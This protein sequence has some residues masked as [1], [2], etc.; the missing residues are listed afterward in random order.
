MP[1]CRELAAEHPALDF[2]GV[3]IADAVARVLRF[4][5]VA[6]KTFLITIADRTVTGLIAR[7][8][9]V[10]PYQVPVA[11]YAMTCHSFKGHTGS[12]MAMG[13]RTPLALVDA[14]ASGRMAIAEAVANIAAAPIG[15]IHHIKLSG[16]WMCAC[17][18]DGEDAALYDTVQAVGMEFCPGLGIAIPV[19]KDSLSMRAIWEDT[20]GQ[21]H[22]IVA[23]LSLVV[24]AFAPVADIRRAATPELKGG[25]DTRLLLVD[26]GQGRRHSSQVEVGSPEEREVIRAGRRN[27]ASITARFIKESI[28]RVVVCFRRGDGRLLR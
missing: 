14:P 12:A 25:N 8:Q 2:S 26:L 16:N 13:E 22:K 18:E 20:Q 10:G 21:A 9:M 7:D 15:E 24:S 3:A 27:D 11:D 4:P 1:S 28:Y 23:P 6:A 17:G 19:G 5:A